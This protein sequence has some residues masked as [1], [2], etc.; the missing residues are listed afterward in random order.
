MRLLQV[1]GTKNTHQKVPSVSKQP[2][3]SKSTKAVQQ[4]L[5]LQF[6]LDQTKYHGHE[7][8]N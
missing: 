6:F 4:L 1:E 5:E 2:I 8:L 7:R 3:S